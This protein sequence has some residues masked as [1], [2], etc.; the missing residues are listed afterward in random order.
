MKT[1]LIK[2][3]RLK[4][5]CKYIL[6]FPESAGVSPE[7]VNMLDHRYVDVVVMLKSTRGVK[8]IEMDKERVKK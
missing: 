7:E 5:G 3:L 6:I 2:K 8:V 1:E 4:K